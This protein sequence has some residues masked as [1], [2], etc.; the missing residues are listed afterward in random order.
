MT[1]RVRMR[2]GI[3]IKA[4]QGDIMEALE[5]RKWTQRQGAE[6]LGLDQTRFGK[7][8]NLK[9]IPEE[10]S[11]ELTIKL[12][13]LTGKTPEE[14]FPDW[15]RQKD[16]LEMSKVSKK[17]IEV[18]SQ[19]L[20]TA[21][22][23]YLPAGPEEAF[24]KQD[25]ERAVNKILQTLSPREEKIVRRHIMDDETLEEISGDFAVSRERIRTICDGALKKM[26]EPVRARILK[27]CLTEKY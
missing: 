14:L 12:F 15:A 24:C 4:K 21:G 2:I 3:I 9:W 20:R 17:I 18:T 7:L 1:R 27:D 25:V 13:E 26:R 22:A 10:F 5:N 8:L 19:M 16:F 11:P 23:L 6:F